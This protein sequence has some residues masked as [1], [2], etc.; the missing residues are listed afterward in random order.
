[1]NSNLD[2]LKNKREKEGAKTGFYSVFQVMFYWKDGTEQ[3]RKDP[4][5]TPHRNLDRPGDGLLSFVR[6]ATRIFYIIYEF[7]TDSW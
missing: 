4:E 2:C 6:T 3:C 1:M 5:S 7:T